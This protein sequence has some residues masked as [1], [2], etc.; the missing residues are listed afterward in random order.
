MKIVSVLIAAVI[1]SGVNSVKSEAI[2][3]KASKG[4]K[5]PETAGVQQPKTY[6]VVAGTKS[7]KT[8]KVLK[9]SKTA[10]L[11]DATGTKSKKMLRSKATG[12]GTDKAANNLRKAG[13]SDS[14]LGP[15]RP[16]SKPTNKKPTNSPVAQSPLGTE[17]PTDKPTKSPL[18]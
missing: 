11:M 1:M 15:K 14:P 5:S 7:A 10:A 9:A 12:N 3:S 2:G 16:T 6:K 18:D 13:K 8:S 4:L 17:K